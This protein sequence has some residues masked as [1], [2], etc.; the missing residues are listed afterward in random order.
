M[1]TI[2]VHDVI[3]YLLARKGSHAS[4]AS[5]HRMAYFAQGWHLAW[6]GAPLFNEEVRT[7]KSGPFIPA[8][9]PHQKDGYTETSW[10]AGNAAAVSSDQA[11]VLNAI[12]AH[13]GHLSGINLGEFAN[14]QAPCL[15]AMQ[16]ATGEDSEPV[17]DL[18]ELKAFFKAL[19]DSPEDRTAYANRFMDRYTDEALQVQP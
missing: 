17:I 9:F 15:L 3:A 13:Y 18:A 19:D 11:S 16:R 7:R 1:T 12:V 8:M 14:A 2:S 5:L 4:T 10:P 6:N